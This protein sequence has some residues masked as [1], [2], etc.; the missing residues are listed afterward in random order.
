MLPPPA[1]LRGN[2]LQNLTVVILLLAGCTSSGCITTLGYV[3]ENIKPRQIKDRRLIPSYAEVK[4]WAYRVQDGLDSRATANRH[5]LYLGAVLAAAAI[6][7]LAGLAVF[8]KG[9]PAI[10][11]IPI[12]TGFLSGVASVYNNDQKA[13]MY[14]RASKYVKKLIDMSD[15]RV[16]SRSIETDA[17]E[18]A[19][20]KA[21]VD[22]LLR[23]VSVHIRY[24]DPKNVVGLLKDLK[25]EKVQTD[26]EEVKAAAGDFSDL[27]S[28]GDKVGSSC[29]RP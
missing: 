7:T 27:D 11:G 12:G 29:V 20:L 10:P 5:A 16:A 6:G 13:D 28:D 1:A 23:R 9:S 14:D 18:A 19:C 22:E 26:S 21:D 4:R 8:D 17:K 3:P 2:R 15:D 25:A 24:M